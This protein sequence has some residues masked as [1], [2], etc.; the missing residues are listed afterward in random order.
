MDPTFK[1]KKRYLLVTEIHNIALNIVPKENFISSRLRSL[2]FR[3][4]RHQNFFGIFVE[5][6]RVG[7]FV[8]ILRNVP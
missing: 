3:K 2:N 4:A 5:C 8:K 6:T 7:R 1:K